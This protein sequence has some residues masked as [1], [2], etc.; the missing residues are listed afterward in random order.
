M[1]ISHLDADV[2]FSII[3][4]YKGRDFITEELKEDMQDLP[5][6]RRVPSTHIAL[7]LKKYR[8]AEPVGEC[9]FMTKFGE[10]HGMVWRPLI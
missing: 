8:L 2:L 3:R 7:V 10:R 5:P 4:S 6:R 9:S 1:S